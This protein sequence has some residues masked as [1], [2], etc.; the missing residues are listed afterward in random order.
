MK[1]YRE[2]PPE[3]GTGLSLHEFKGDWAQ[4]TYKCSL[5]S[6]EMTEEEIDFIYSLLPKWTK[7]TKSGMGET[8]YGTL[9]HEGDLKVINKVK[10]I[11][12][13]L[14]GNEQRISQKV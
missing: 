3:K 14:K 1:L 13:K 10:A 11:L 2:V 4:P 6:I 12:S 8:F 7:E 9:S 5:E